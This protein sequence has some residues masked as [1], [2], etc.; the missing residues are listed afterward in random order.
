MVRLADG[1]LSAKGIS[2]ANKLVADKL[3]GDLPLE[4]DTNDSSSLSAIGQ[5]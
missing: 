3:A 4:L 1:R 5:R 2:R